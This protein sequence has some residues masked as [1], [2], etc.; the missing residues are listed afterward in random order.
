MTAAVLGFA[1]AV[2][3]RCVREDKDRK[4]LI[5]VE[6]SYTQRARPLTR[7]VSQSS[8]QLS[9][10]LQEVGPAQVILEIASALHV[11]HH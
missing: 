11:A 10:R 2:V 7:L 6:G 3:L 9:G 8:V 1:D 4:A 5:R